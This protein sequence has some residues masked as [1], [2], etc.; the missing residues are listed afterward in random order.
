VT[1]E[2]FLAVF[3]MESLQE[4]PDREGLEDAGLGHHKTE[5]V[6]VE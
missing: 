4:L 2:R 6:R 1:S 3:G 5:S